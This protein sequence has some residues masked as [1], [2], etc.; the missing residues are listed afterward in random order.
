MQLYY[1]SNCSLN[2]KTVKLVFKNET[3]YHFQNHTIR[4]VFYAKGIKDFEIANDA[5]KKVAIKI[6]NRMIKK[7]TNT[8]ASKHSM[9]S[10]RFSSKLV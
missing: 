6:T 8:Y 1:H 4:I 2:F 3:V 9:V 10:L 5:V 7:L